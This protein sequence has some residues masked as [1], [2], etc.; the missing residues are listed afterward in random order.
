MIISKLCSDNFIN[1]ISYLEPEEIDKVY[2]IF[3]KQINK[4]YNIFLRY[5]VLNLISTKKKAWLCLCNKITCVNFHY[6]N[7]KLCKK[8]TYVS[9]Y[10]SICE[11]CLEY[12]KCGYCGAYLCDGNCIDY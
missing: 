1:I 12:N 11:E 9:R 3:Y 4:K 7:C 10:W 2:I 5:I 8:L 6:R